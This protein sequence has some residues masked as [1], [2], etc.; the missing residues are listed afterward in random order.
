MQNGGGLNGNQQRNGGNQPNGTNG[1]NTPKKNKKGQGPGRRPAL[2][3]NVRLKIGGKYVK[4][5]VFC[6]EIVLNMLKIESEP[7]RNLKNRENAS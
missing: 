7:Y 2:D 5:R 4:K 6:I 3:A 1:V